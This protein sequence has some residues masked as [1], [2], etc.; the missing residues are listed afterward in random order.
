MRMDSLNLLNV[1]FLIKKKSHAYPPM[2]VIQCSK[3]GISCPRVFLDTGSV[4]AVRVRSTLPSC[5][6]A[7]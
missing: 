2:S 1:Q 3:F 7:Q 4:L 6:H 5:A